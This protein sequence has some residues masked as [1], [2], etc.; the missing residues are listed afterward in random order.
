MV[1]RDPSWSLGDNVSN[2]LTSCDGNKRA[3]KGKRAD[4]QGG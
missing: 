1:E 2:E 4:K 3:G